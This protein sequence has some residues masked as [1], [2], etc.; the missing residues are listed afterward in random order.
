MAGQD[1]R[2]IQDAAQGEARAH[3]SVGGLVDYFIL[4]SS[5]KTVIKTQLLTFL[6]LPYFVLSVS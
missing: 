3:L 6:K 5:L 1:G 2:V 4:F